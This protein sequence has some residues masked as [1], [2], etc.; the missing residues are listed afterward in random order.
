[1]KRIVIVGATSGI[2]LETARA[3]LRKGW[4]VGA[5]GRRIDALERLQAETPGQVEIEQI[6]ITCEDAPERFE[7]LAGKLGG[8]DIYLHC[9]GIGTQNPALD[10]GVETATCQ[11][12]VLGFVR[13]MTAVFDYFSRCGGGHI[14]VVTSIAGTKGL[15]L[16]PAY[17]ATK[18]FESTYLDALAQLAQMKHADIRFTDIRP[19]FVATPMLHDNYPML[20]RPEKV[21]RHILRAL[22]SRKRR[23]VIDGR[24]AVLVFIWKLIPG[25]LWERLRI[26]NR[27]EQLPAKKSES[28][29]DFR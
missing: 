10:P 7:K 24:Y 8:V 28:V 14:A 6:D 11:T 20:M 23:I 5:A 9:A 29:G 17:S 3:C 13:M 1:M 22:E 26:C 16:A 2:G 18:R 25:W 19:G 15:G 21:A 27:P 12:N 4:R